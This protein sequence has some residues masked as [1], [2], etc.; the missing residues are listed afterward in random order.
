AL[1]YPDGPH[2]SETLMVDPA[3]GDL[4]IVTKSS[5]RQA[6]YRAP[7]APA[8]GA[9][10]VL[11]RVGEV[12][13]RGSVSLTQRAVA[14]DI[15]PSGRWSLVKSYDVVYRY[16]AGLDPWYADTPEA[17]PYV[18]EPQGE[19]I[20]W[21][22]DESGYFTLS[23]EA[24]GVPAILYYYPLSPREGQIRSAMLRE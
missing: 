24:G 22:A 17:M 3:T 16:E 8:G 6:V 18:P 2:N 10:F 9:A 15:S 5:G 4:Y 14:G 12:A 1:T 13:L 21:A 23:E 7:L 19:A 11:E 20:A